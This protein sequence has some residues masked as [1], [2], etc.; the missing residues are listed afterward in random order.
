MKMNKQK[1]KVQA[2]NQ[3][4]FELILAKGLAALNQAGVEQL[5]STIIGLAGNVAQYITE[6]PDSITHHAATMEIMLLA[7]QENANA[8]PLTTFL[9]GEWEAGCEL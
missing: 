7:L 2:V 9:D 4:E 1:L 3:E 5:R 6:T 8:T